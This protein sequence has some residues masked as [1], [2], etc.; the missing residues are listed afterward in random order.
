LLIDTS[1]D[2]VLEIVE[3]LL[4]RIFDFLLFDLFSKTL[5]NML[6]CEIFVLQCLGLRGKRFLYG[7]IHQFR[8]L[9]VNE[10]TKRIL[11][12]VV[13][14]QI[15]STECAL[16]N[17]FFA[18]IFLRRFFWLALIRTLEELAT[19]SLHPFQ[20]LCLFLFQFGSIQSLFSVATFSYLFFL[21]IVSFLCLIQLLM[22]E[23]LRLDRLK[24]LE[25]V[26]KHVLR[27]HIDFRIV[28][29]LYEAC[30]QLLIQMGS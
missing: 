30:Y 25:N 20:H 24:F 14:M 27:F 26:G 5:V 17:L 12:E 15:F 28:F 1:V 10:I 29:P 4:R 6:G 19:S 23:E 18:L 22:I 3:F 8:A 9:A 16:M 21:Q 11:D 7:M 13:T 2:Q